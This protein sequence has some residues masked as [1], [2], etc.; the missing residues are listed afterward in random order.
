MSTPIPGVPVIR[1][2]DLTTMPYMNNPLSDIQPFTRRDTRTYLDLVMDLAD[3]VTES[4]KILNDNQGEL[5]TGWIQNAEALVTEVNRIANDLVEAVADNSVTLQDPV[6]SA[7]IGNVNSNTRQIINTLLQGVVVPDGA[8]PGTFTVAGSASLKA[9][10]VNAAG[11]LPDR[12]RAVLND[13]YA[14]VRAYAN[15]AYPNR[16]AGKV[17]VWVGGPHPGLLASPIDIYVSPNDEVITSVV[18]GILS[19]GSPLNLAVRK[20]GTDIIPVQIFPTV[21]SSSTAVTIGVDP[22]QVY[23]YSLAK[24]GNTNS[25]RYGGFIPPWWTRARLHV[26]W[27]HDTGAGQIRVARSARQ[28]DAN[29]VQ[30]NDST[31][32]N[33]TSVGIMRANDASFTFDVVGGRNISGTIARLSGSTGNDDLNAPII[34]TD[35]YLERVA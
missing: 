11:E 34:I 20:V 16:V 31:T 33:N 15:G 10:G 13:T 19:P 32:S 22:N 24:D 17:N 29:G 35:A 28:F 14:I 4:A 2:I 3:W 7:L 30:A 1:P 27:M 21:S 5:S 25:V 6:M 9:V 23:G 26:I 18:N 8:D 12:V